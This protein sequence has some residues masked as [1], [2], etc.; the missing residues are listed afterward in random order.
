[1]W[2]A[3]LPISIR[4]SASS[5]SSAN[6]FKSIQKLLFYLFCHIPLSTKKALSQCIRKLPLTVPY[7]FNYRLWSKAKPITKVET[8]PPNHFG[9]YIP[10]DGQ[11]T[12]CAITNNS[13]LM[14]NVTY[15][16]ELY[17]DIIPSIYYYLITLLYDYLIILLCA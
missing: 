9:S 17:Q 15:K 5:K 16:R 14:L 2:I 6:D 8:S 7:K 3:W 4:H 13:Q 12:I 10:T 1:M 11:N